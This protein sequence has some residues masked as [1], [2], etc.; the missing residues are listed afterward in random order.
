MPML[1][2][3]VQKRNQLKE[4]LLMMD[5]DGSLES[6]EGR[7]YCQLLVRVTVIQLEIESL[8]NKEKIAPTK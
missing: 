1:Q 2:E 6:E 4:V 8:L 7:I 3:L 5:K